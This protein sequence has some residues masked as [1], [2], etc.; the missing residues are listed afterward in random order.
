MLF[1]SGLSVSAQQMGIDIAGATLFDESGLVINNAGEDYSSSLAMTSTFFMGI[2][3]NNQWDNWGS[4]KRSWRIEV[5][6]EDM[7]WDNNLKLEITRTGDGNWWYYFLFGSKIYGGQNYQTIENNSTYFFRGK[8]LLTDIPVQL[9]LSGVSVTQG[10][11]DYETNIIL[12]IY[13][14]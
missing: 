2:H 6:K 7:N 14:D 11:G 9:R 13:D 5:Q 4:T 12:T 3:S 8:G 10:A 1:F